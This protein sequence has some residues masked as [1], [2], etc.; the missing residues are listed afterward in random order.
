ML[1]TETTSGSVPDKVEIS[2]PA[3]EFLEHA[4][5]ELELRLSLRQ[6]YENLLQVWKNT[7][8]V[9]LEKSQDEI[10]AKGLK[11]YFE[12]WKA[13]QTPPKPEDIQQLLDQEY[14]TFT[15]P[16]DVLKYTANDGGGETESVEHISFTVRELPQSVEKKFYRQ[17]KDKLLG[18]LQMLEAFTQAG[19]DKSFEDKAKAFLGLFD[20]SFDMLAEAV[21]LVINPFDRRKEINT[22]WVQDNISSDRQWR[23]I[24]AQMKV[25]RLRDFF[26]KVST[27]G[28]NMRMMTSPNFRTLQGLVA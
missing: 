16:I 6:E 19:M 23:I 22:K 26:S 1:D 15:I 10:I 3:Q 4:K 12:D 18:K 21:V 14:E 24:E 25:N 20:E 28:Q 7:E 9:A 8:F 27:S 11:K 2:K 17:F 5:L 13:E